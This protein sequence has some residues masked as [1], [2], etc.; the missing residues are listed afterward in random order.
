MPPPALI[1]TGTLNRLMKLEHQGAVIPLRIKISG[2]KGEITTVMKNPLYNEP[3]IGGN[4]FGQDVGNFTK[5]FGRG[6]SNAMKT[7]APILNAAGD[8]GVL[9]GT[10]TGQPE[11][12]AAAGAAKAA[13][14][15]AGGSDAFVKKKPLKS[16]RYRVTTAA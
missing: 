2:E 4:G 9:L 3:P 12:V 6:F 10:V 5:G 16:L 1:V 7:A 13:G 8:A 11:V 15:L 14:E